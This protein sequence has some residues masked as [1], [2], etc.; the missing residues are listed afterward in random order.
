MDTWAKIRAGY[1]SGNVINFSD[2]DTCINFEHDT[3]TSG[4]IRGQHCWVL[5]AALPNSTLDDN[6]AD[7]SLK[8]L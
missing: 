3:T 8:N 1:L 6:R 2:F 4:I 5:L 7:L